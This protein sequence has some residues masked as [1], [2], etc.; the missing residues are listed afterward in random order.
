MVERNRPVVTTVEVM[1]T[2]EQHPVRIALAALEKPQA[3][4]AAFLDRV[5]GSN[6]EL[7]RAVEVLVA[8]DDDERGVGDFLE[9]PIAGLAGQLADMWLQGNAPKST[10]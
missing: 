10:D 9:P 7:R 4:R 8:E 5:C 2:A 3:D 6:R 1:A